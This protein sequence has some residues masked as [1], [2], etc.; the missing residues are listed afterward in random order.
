[1]IQQLKPLEVFIREYL[2]RVQA[3]HD[4]GECAGVECPWCAYE[5]Q[6]P[7]KPYYRTIADTDGR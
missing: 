2:A 4:D 3:M 6:H 1:M 7:G 5:R